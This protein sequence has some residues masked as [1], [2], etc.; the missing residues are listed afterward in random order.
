[1]FGTRETLGHVCSHFG[2]LLRIRDPQVTRPAFDSCRSS[3]P[4]K[5]P[6]A[7]LQSACRWYATCGAG[8]RMLDGGAVAHDR[9]AHPTMTIRLTLSFGPDRG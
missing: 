9:D 2:L 7:E 1:V 6:P 4:K 3:C 5:S 8:I